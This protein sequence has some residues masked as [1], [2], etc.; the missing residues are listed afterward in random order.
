MLQVC[1]RENRL[2]T[3]HGFRER[4]RGLTKGKRQKVVRFLISPKKKKVKI[5]LEPKE[6]QNLEKRIHFDPKII[7]LKTKSPTSVSNHKLLSVLE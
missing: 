3:A 2:E 7:K 5:E 6:M 4:K 1:K